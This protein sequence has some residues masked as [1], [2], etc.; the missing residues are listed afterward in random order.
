MDALTLRRVSVWLDEFAPAASAFPHALEWAARLALPLHAVTPSAEFLT[1]DR[2]R[3][4]ATACARN[5]VAW[6]VSPAPD[7]MAEARTHFFRPL[8]L[9]VL[10]DGLPPSLR[11]GLLR[12]SLHGNETCVLVCP[13]NWQP[14]SRILVLH[15]ESDAGSDFLL[16]ALRLCRALAV[17]PVVLTV[18]R[19]EVESRRQQTLAEEVC[20]AERLVADFD[21]MVGC[22]VPQAV[23]RVARW[24]RCTHV[25]LEKQPAPPWWRGRRRDVL[26]EVLGLGEPLTLLA[27]PASGGVYPRR[28]QPG[29]SPGVDRFPRVRGDAPCG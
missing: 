29:G 4:C 22:D 20:A 15:Q 5:G 27:V 19:S 18:A 3:L 2:L 26:T 7:S 23:A 6:D 8:E 25:F 14:A 1:A 24:R 12:E 9:C 11:D 28:G 21:V 10:G 13:R 16:S 17:T